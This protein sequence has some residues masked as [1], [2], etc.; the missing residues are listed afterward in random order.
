MDVLALAMFAISSIVVAGLPLW[1]KVRKIDD[2]VSNS[3][4]ENLRD[5][6]TRGFREVREDIRSL[7]EA[8]NIE[9]RDRIAGD[10]RECCENND[11]A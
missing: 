6:I 1:L 9:R 7:H 10:R 3:H 11:V 4:T 5:E 2:Q 8:L